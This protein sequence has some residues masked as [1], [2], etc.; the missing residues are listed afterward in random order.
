[1]RG[2]DWLFFWIISVLLA[3]AAMAQ[4]FMIIGFSGRSGVRSALE[5]D[6]RAEEY[7]MLEAKNLYLSLQGRRQFVL[8]PEGTGDF[9]TLSGKCRELLKEALALSVVQTDLGALSP[10]DL[11]GETVC[12][13]ELKTTGSSQMIRSEMSLPENRF[14]EGRF[15]QIWIRPALSVTDDVEIYFLD[16]E[17]GTLMMASGGSYRLETNRNL[18][19]EIIAVGSAVEADYV[20]QGDAFPE[21]FAE[22][23]FLR[24]S[25][26]EMGAKGS[27][28]SPFLSEE[29]VL[30]TR[31]HRYGMSFFEFPDTVSEQMMGGADGETD[32]LLSNEKITL[33]LSPEG[34][35]V[36]VETLT[37]EEKEAVGL[38]Q[39]YDIASGFIRQDMSHTSGEQMDFYL[40]SFEEA[41]GDFI[42]CF[43][44]EIASLPLQME[45]LLQP[46]GMEA[47]IVVTVQGSK[48]RRYERCLVK[49]ELSSE[50][51]LRYSWLQMADRCVEDGITLLGPPRLSYRLSHGQLILFWLIPTPEG[52]E[53]RFAL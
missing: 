44:Y 41:G 7:T 28:S 45:E 9:E 26:K 6:A 52:E 13:L 34:K 46:L 16:S 20:W 14:P 22:S 3:G 11:L 2:R 10:E 18:L 5:G 12:V 36:Y 8:V 32:L 19:E 40:R 4:I 53:L 30:G 1:M 43:D 21:I 24:L 29:G 38:K 15:D 48:V 35:V 31:M 47:P 39:A 49:V 42:F 17:G 51:T 27:L 33:R 37:E 50:Q 23:G 25:G